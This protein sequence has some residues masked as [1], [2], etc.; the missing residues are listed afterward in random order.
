[1]E[2]FKPGVEQEE[3][4]NQPEEEEMP[5]EEYLE[6]DLVFSF[7]NSCIYIMECF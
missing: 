1:M 5:Y 2:E 3:V 4:T 7:L 6:S